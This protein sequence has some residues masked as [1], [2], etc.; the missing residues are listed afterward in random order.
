MD[1]YKKPVIPFG[2]IALY[3]L[4]IFGVQFVVM[5]IAI[6]TPLYIGDFTP[7]EGVQ[8]YLWIL[9]PLIGIIT[10]PVVGFIG[11]HIWGRYGRRG[12]TILSM[13]L[14]GAI[15]LIA[16]AYIVNPIYLIIISGVV[17]IAINALFVSYRALVRE[18]TPDKE[19]SS[20][21]GVL[22]LLQLLAILSAILLHLWIRDNNIDIE[23]S[24]I[25]GIPFFAPLLMII[26]AIL[27]LVTALIGLVFLREYRSFGNIEDD[28][29]LP[30]NMH[31]ERE[32]ID[33]NKMSYARQGAIW[34]SITAITLIV[35]SVSNFSTESYV[36]PFM[37]FILAI[38]LM[39]AHKFNIKYKEKNP[40]I[41]RF[42]ELI[43]DIM[44]M[45]MVMKK[46]NIVMMF[47]WF[48]IFM[49]MANIEGIIAQDRYLNMYMNFSNYGWNSVTSCYIIIISVA[50]AFTPLIMLF[51]A[52]HGGY[53]LLSVSL[54]V[55]AMTLFLYYVLG[56]GWLFIVVLSLF[57]ILLAVMMSTPYSLVSY[58][59]P[60]ERTGVFLGLM[61]VF[62]YV[63]YVM[64]PDISQTFIISMNGLHLNTM[65]LSIISFMVGLIFSMTITSKDI[66]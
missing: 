20:G 13:G 31:S 12:G 41:S 29:Y 37:M 26:G 65:I 57:G 64:T 59:I 23:S 38:F 5:V 48:G 56:Y 2:R 14:I 66:S 47:G 35:F 61:S 42:T 27:M 53:N 54:I 50:I 39:A 15:G 10:Q 33:N 24:R 7:F 3:N 44:N 34:L 63:P 21:Y 6:S 16:M 43:Y 19:R 55:N 51:G 8:N 36:I 22:S 18:I 40:T 30:F 32:L 52:K 17:L 58:R 28:N 62:V 49:F 9:I 46:T 45:P 60:S 11:D 1:S 4:G 25:N